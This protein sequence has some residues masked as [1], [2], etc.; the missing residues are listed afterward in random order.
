VG[1]T[2][3]PGAIDGEKWQ[4]QFQAAKTPMGQSLAAPTPPPDTGKVTYTLHR[5]EEPTEE[6]QKLF[7]Q[8]DKSM[9]EAVGFY[10]RYTSLK[11]HLNVTFNPAIMGNNPPPG[12]PKTPTLPGADW[13]ILSWKQSANTA[14][15]NAL[16]EK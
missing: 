8:I 7:D 2:P 3:T 16:N 12:L 15:V 5:P 10:N 11:K 1:A 9:K 4:S 14:E 6:Q 13:R